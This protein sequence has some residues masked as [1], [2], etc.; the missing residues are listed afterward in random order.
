MIEVINT[1][2]TQVQSNALLGG[3]VVIWL[4][5]VAGVLLREIPIKIINFIKHHTTVTVY[6][7]STHVVFHKLMEHL[8]KVGISGKFR[9]IK[10]RSG[11]WGVGDDTTKGLG[12]GSQLLWYNK[13]PIWISLKND[14]KSSGE[15]EKDALS[16]TV[17]GR[18]HK[19][20]DTFI[21]DVTKKD[22]VYR[23]NFLD[24]TMRTGDNSYECIKYQ[25]K[26]K[27]DTVYIPEAN[28]KKIT[29][30]ITNFRNNEQWYIDHGIPYRL[31]IMFYGP[32]GTGKTSLAKAIASHYNHDIAIVPSSKIDGDLLG[33]LMNVDKDSLVVIE[34]IDRS[35]A[36]KNND[37]SDKNKN[38]QQNPLS[39]T[40]SAISQSNFGDILNAID[41]LVSTH[42]RI[43][44]MTAN[45]IDKI[46][47]ALL[48]PGRIDL[49]LE[50]GYCC[51]ESFDACMR[52]FFGPEYKG[53]DTRTEL[54]GE[55]T[56]AQLQNDILLG[57][58]AQEIM[59]LRLK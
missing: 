27:L 43:L 44:I 28:K 6:V 32:P 24:I 40:I 15:M 13:K 17:I 45:N 5:T 47:P 23:E 55:F 50:I 10:L 34:D 51:Y 56:N 2:I 36:V 54:N 14:D 8:D 53:S 33:F 37:K 1:F 21:I 9:N 12:Y 3:F 57:L 31:G 19:F 52:A 48:R 7:Y 39:D 35:A 38:S 59:N 4:T 16:L 58:S 30:T 25:A 20:I 22:Y 49:C 26:R 46:D 29:D 41:G 42:G 11:R 18:S